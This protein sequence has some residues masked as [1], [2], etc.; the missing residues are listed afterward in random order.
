MA[1]QVPQSTCAPNSSTQETLVPVTVDGVA[2]DGWFGSTRKRRDFGAGGRSSGGSGA[3]IDVGL[4]LRAAARADRAKLGSSRRAMS[5][6][7]ASAS[8][9]QET[10]EI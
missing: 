3:G 10:P 4:V 2:L 7:A 6:A 1:G 8:L 5:S 9:A